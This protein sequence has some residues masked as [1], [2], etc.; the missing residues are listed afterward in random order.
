MPGEKN[1]RNREGEDAF[2]TGKG[3]LRSR[4]NYAGIKLFL[5]TLIRAGEVQYAERDVDHRDQC[6][7]DGREL[8][9]SWPFRSSHRVKLADPSG[10]ASTTV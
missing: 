3:P 2:Q 8:Q 5:K 10:L 4:G 7:E 9:Q 6:G 1:C